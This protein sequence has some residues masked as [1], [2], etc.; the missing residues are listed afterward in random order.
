[1][2]ILQSQRQLFNPDNRLFLCDSSVC[3]DQIEEITSFCVAQEY[4]KTCAVAQIYCALQRCADGD[5][6]QECSIRDTEIGWD[7]FLELFLCRLFYRPVSNKCYWFE[8]LQ[9]IRP[10]RLPRLI[11]S[12]IDILFYQR[13]FVL[14]VLALLIYPFHSKVVFAHQSAIFFFVKTKP[15]NI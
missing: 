7:S 9:G 15:F 2:Q 1:M 10:R 12:T 11:S 6:S 5:N 4:K 3:M 13:S 14:N 8:I